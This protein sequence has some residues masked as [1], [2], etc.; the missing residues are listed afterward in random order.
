MRYTLTVIDRDRKIATVEVHADSDEEAQ[1]IGERY[2]TVIIIASY[3]EFEFS[4]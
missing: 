2:G 3:D 4:E 1:R